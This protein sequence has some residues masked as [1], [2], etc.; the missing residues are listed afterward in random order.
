M[1]LRSALHQRFHRDEVSLQLDD[2]QALILRNRPE[3]YVGVHAMLHI[4][5]PA[6]GRD[7]VARRAPP[8]P[9]AGGGRLHIYEAPRPGSRG[10]L[11]ASAG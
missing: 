9:T 2:I 5:D 1:G 8:H 10:R 7:L 11:P 4:D 6:G 3:P